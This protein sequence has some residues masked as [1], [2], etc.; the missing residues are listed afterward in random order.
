MKNDVYKDKLSER[1]EKIIQKTQKE[2][3]ACIEN[4]RKHGSIR[5]QEV[6]K[7]SEKLLKNFNEIITPLILSRDVNPN[8]R[9]E[10]QLAIQSLLISVTKT[11]SQLVNDRIKITQLKNE[12]STNVNTERYKTL[13]DCDRITQLC[14]VMSAISDDTLSKINQDIKQYTALETILR[15]L[16]VMTDI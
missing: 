16:L 14:G 8:K 7:N 4:D 12:L 6:I 3:D 13:S 11:L 5:S 2:L 10:S 15:S 9:L 1:C